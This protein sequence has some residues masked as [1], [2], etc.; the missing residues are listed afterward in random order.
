M[1]LGVGWIQLLLSGSIHSDFKGVTNF[2]NWLTCYPE[3]LG[4]AVSKQ[5]KTNLLEPDPTAV[6]GV[7]VGSLP[8]RANCFML[9]SLNAWNKEIPR[10]SATEKI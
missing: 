7:W 1:P 2:S 9:S 8:S 5:Q 10:K 4:R 6:L 3:R